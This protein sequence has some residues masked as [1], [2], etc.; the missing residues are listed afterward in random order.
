MALFSGNALAE[1]FIKVTVDTDEAN[2]KLGDATKSASSFGSTFK[3]I[4][5]SQIVTKVFDLVVQGAQKAA[6]ALVGFIKDVVNL[7]GEYEQLEG[8]IKKIFGVGAQSLEEY[9]SSQGKSVDEVRG[10]YNELVETQNTALK[11]AWD[12]WQFAGLSANQYMGILT[13]ISGALMGDLNYNSQEAVEYSRRAVTDMSDIANTYGMSLEEVSGYYISFSRGLYQT[14]DTLTSGTYKGTKEGAKSL[15]NDMA[16]LKDIQEE[17]GV[18]VEKDNLSYANFVNAMSVYNE[19]VGI[20]GTTASEASQTIQGSINQLKAAWENLKIGI[21]DPSADLDVLL[22]NVISSAETALDNLIPVIERALEGI[23][24][25]VEKIAPIVEKELPILL[26]EL[27]PH[28]ENMLSSLIQIGAEVLV[29]LAPVILEAGREIIN[30][31]LAELEESHPLIAFGLENLFMPGAGVF[32]WSGKYGE[33]AHE[34]AMTTYGYLYDGAEQTSTG[35][36]QQF[37]GMTSGVA[38]FMSSMTANVTGESS[39]M[40]GTFLGNIG[41]MV[42]GN[43]T[44]FTQMNTDATT[45]TETMKTSVLEKMLGIQTGTSDYTNQMYMASSSNFSSMESDANTKASNINKNFVNNLSQM[46]STNSSSMSDINRKMSSAWSS[47]DS[48][49]STKWSN[50]SRSIGGRMLDVTN[51]V[52]TRTSSMMST[53]SNTFSRVSSTMVNPFDDAYSQIDGRVSN[54]RGLLNF[55]WSFPR[56]QLPHIGWDWVNLGGFLSFP[57]LRFEGWWAK[58]YDRPYLLNTATVLGNNGFGDRGNYNGGELVYGHDNLMDDIREATGGNEG[59][60]DITINIYPRQDQDER[61]IAEAVQKQLVRWES[62]RR[63]A[64]A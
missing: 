42:S 37:D 15:I 18:T 10:K 12:A 3:A 61:A 14:L 6:S 20:A 23:G 32:K 17:L 59:G 22:D 49:T 36:Q 60:G 7:Y 56:P 19:K 51:A 33:I 48:D 28:I 5:G 62:Q 30:A 39:T 2:R 31:L 27:K 64:F 58:G 46:M 52:S 9:A 24:T 29:D 40:S 34:T 1:V 53:L 57:K 45:Q 54:I 13:S 8:G 47:A 38:S 21:G 35:V 63:K 43:S 50:I 11:D 26:E 16:D 44:G 25:L 4:L 55:S 41:S